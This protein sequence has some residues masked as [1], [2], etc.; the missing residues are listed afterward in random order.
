MSTRKGTNGELFLDDSIHDSE[1]IVNPSDEISSGKS[2][3]PVKKSRKANSQT[4]GK[5]ADK[6]PEAEHLTGM[7][8]QTVARYARTKVY[9]SAIPRLH[10]QKRTAFA[11]PLLV[12]IAVQALLGV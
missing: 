1:P 2:S 11:V 9:V 7:Q 4:S 3:E 12:E 6:D 5:T 8:K 10:Q